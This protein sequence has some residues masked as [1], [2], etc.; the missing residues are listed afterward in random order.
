[1]QHLLLHRRFFFVLNHIF[2]FVNCKSSFMNVL[3]KFSVSLCSTLVFYHW[4]HIMSATAVCQS[5]SSHCVFSWPVTVLLPTACIWLCWFS[6]HGGTPYFYSDTHANTRQLIERH[7]RIQFTTAASLP[8]MPPTYL[9]WYVT[10]W[11]V[12]ALC[13][14]IPWTRATICSSSLLSAELSIKSGNGPLLC[15]SDMFPS[16]AERLSRSQFGNKAFQQFYPQ[17]DENYRGVVTTV[18]AG[19]QF[20]SRTFTRRNCSFW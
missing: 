2:V 6:T 5:L 7:A 15:L 4:I 3:C 9:C 11:Q 16:A 8:K 13:S 12:S 18:W 20:Y 14:S 10:R 1:M 17:M 19:R